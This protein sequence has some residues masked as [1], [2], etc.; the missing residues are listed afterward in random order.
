[1][2]SDTI[3]VVE[4]LRQSGEFDEAWY[5]AAYPDVVAAGL[6]PIRHYLEFG[7]R[8][9]RNPNPSFCS[10]GYL[11]TYADA[12]DAGVNPLVH[13]V[14]YGR[15]KGHSR[16]EPFDEGFYL[17][18]YGDVR[19][20]VAAG[21]FRNGYDHWVHHGRLEGRTTT[22]P[23]T[24]QYSSLPKVSI[25]MP[26]FNGGKYFRAA[27]ESAIS[28]TYANT[29]IVVVDDGSDD[30]A[31]AAAV[32]T[33]ASPKV[34]YIRQTNK[35]V[36]AALNVAVAKMTG[37]FFTWLSHDDLFVPEKTAAQVEFYQQL[38]R[39]AALLFSNYDIIDG[40]GRP[41][42]QIRL[43]AEAIRRCPLLPMHRG[44]INGCTVFL[45]LELLRQ[46]GPFDERL[47]YTQDYDMWNRLVDR[48]EFFLQQRSLIRSR[49]HPGQ[50]TH[51]PEAALEGDRLWVEI[52]DRRSTVQRCHL[53]GSSK[54]YFDDLS[55]FLEQTPYQRAAMYARERARRAIEDTLV[56]VVLPVMEEAGPAR[57][58]VRSVLEQNHSRLELIVVAGVCGAAA[59][60]VPGRDARV[61]QITTR[62][63]SLNET[64][65][66]G[67]KAAAGEYV[68]LLKPRDRFAPAKI[69]I[70]LAAMQETGSRLSHTSYEVHSPGS[71]SS[72]N[73]INSGRFSGRVHPEMV[74]HCSL[75]TST[76][77]LHRSIVDA[78]FNFPVDGESAEQR[79]WIS[80][81]ADN[82]LLGID[83]QLTVIDVSGA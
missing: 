2:C 54:R 21:Q 28:Q 25:A 4:L 53:S 9:G 6:D 3:D 77:M 16:G 47:R 55:K 1:M 26:V 75:A 82:E 58:A 78:G 35:G 8:E 32:E 29:E 69:G 34:V 42:R 45:P 15:D 76:V 57:G 60:D 30:G 50:G 64:W 40:E 56:S 7:A 38:G 79:L 68:A 51:R 12:A 83:D 63:R 46:A 36:A 37:E 67:L 5:L 61:R 44:W 14:L 33:C 59:V 22:R 19:E 49:S 24:F 17:D 81:T 20:A 48:H 72:G 65:N 39:S 27:L 18:T 80:L 70:Q 52:I 74:A 62:G 71:A 11:A 66:V 10:G 13:Y 31:A 41:V 23:A 73:R 43:D